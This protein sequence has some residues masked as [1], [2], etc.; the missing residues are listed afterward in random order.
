MHTQTLPNNNKLPNAQ[1][2]YPKIVKSINFLRLSPEHH[3][4]SLISNY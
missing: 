3:K 4:H 2:K 1:T